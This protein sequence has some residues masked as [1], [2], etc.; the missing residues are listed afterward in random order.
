MPLLVVGAVCAFALFRR[1]G[2]SGRWAA[3]GAVTALGG[4]ILLV[5]RFSIGLGGAAYGPRHAIPVIALLYA[6]L[7]ASSWWRLRMPLRLLLYAMAVWSVLI[8]GLGTLNPWTRYALSVY[9]PLDVVAERLVANGRSRIAEGIVRHTA[10]NAAHGLS[11]MAYLNWKAGYAGDAIA[12]FEQALEI[13]PNRG[14]A[15]Y[16]LA[17]VAR[18]VGRTEQARRML[19]RFVKIDTSSAWAWGYLGKLRLEHG[20]VGGSRAALE[21]A[22]SLEPE[23]PAALEGMVQ[24]HSAR[25]EKA[26][27]RKYEEMLARGTSRK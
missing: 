18:D 22:L 2:A 15:L 17:M 6:F 20:D 26:R 27:A 4:I 13:E 19:E 23:N 1:T 21:K 8:A 9:A 25:G 24:W 14:E 5:P 11:R 10:P 7:P 12:T 3:V 16:G